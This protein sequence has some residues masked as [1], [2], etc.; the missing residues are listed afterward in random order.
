M[1]KD[2]IKD[3][4]R[5]YVLEMTYGDKDKIKDQT[6]LFKEGLFDSMGFVNLLQF[7]EDT[8]H[9]QSNDEDL[10]ED[11]F[12]SIDAIATFVMVKEPA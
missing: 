9:V 6:L 2:Q 12:E 8:F 4:I 11:N 5:N 7:L 3:K 10:V 1:Q